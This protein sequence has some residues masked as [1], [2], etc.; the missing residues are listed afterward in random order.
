MSPTFIQAFSTFTNWNTVPR[1]LLI[2]AFL[3]LAACASTPQSAELFSAGAKSEFL[4]SVLLKNVPF[5][6]QQ[7]YQCGPASLATILQAADVETTP[8]ELVAQVYLPDRQGSLQV[9]ML[10]TARRQGRI[11]YVLPSSLASVLKEVRQGR[12]V[13]VMQNLG[14]SWYARWHYAVVVGYDLQ[15]K[16]LVLNSGRNEHYR[17]SLPLFERTWQR[18]DRW[19]MIVLAPGQLPIDAEELPYL[20]AL[21]ALAITRPDMKLE[22]A[23]LAGTDRWPNSL[24]LNMGLGNLYYSQGQPQ[25]AIR[26][27]TYAL[28]LD[29]D[30]ASAHNNLAQVL[31][32]SG[33]KALALVHAQNAVI[34]GGVH[35][36]IF[37]KTLETIRRE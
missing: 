31:F 35:K 1:L 32:E 24:L 2:L 6:S 33:D 13:L 11:A 9:E 18:A 15:Q 10:A 23:Y 30:Y 12:P 37:E 3:S 19:A 8:D 21:T 27:F 4:D 25:A 20:S 28:S 16:E 36:E 34:L 17:V 26:A 14:L 7:D 5:N 22:A 29:P